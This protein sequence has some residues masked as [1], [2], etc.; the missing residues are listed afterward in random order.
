[1]DLLFIA[2]TS[3][4]D[5]ISN[6]GRCYNYLTSSAINWHGARNMCLALGGDLATVTSLEENTMMYNIKSGTSHCWIG[7]NDIDVQHTFVWADDSESTYRK[8]SS[9]EP[10]NAFGNEDCVEIWPNQA[11]NDDSCEAT[12]GCYFC[13]TTGQ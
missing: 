2:P 3:G 11:W 6:E 10:N 12:K 4:C 1:M 9:G 5:A 7:L 8:W 13:S